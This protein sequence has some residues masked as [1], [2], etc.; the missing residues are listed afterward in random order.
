MDQGDQSSGSGLTGVTQ[1]AISAMSGQPLSLA[2]LLINCV[3]LGFSGYL[4]KQVSENSAERNKSQTEMIQ[5]LIRECRRAGT[6]VLLLTLAGCS[7][8]VAW[9]PET[10]EEKCVGGTVNLERRQVDTLPGRVRNTVT[11]ANACLD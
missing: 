3:F 2:L 8:R 5:S 10:P 9:V 4:L 1:S 7:G 6:I 11:R